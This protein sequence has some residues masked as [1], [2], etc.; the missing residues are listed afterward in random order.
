MKM[1][2]LREVVSVFS[3][4]AKGAGK[5]ILSY[6]GKVI[7]LRKDYVTTNEEKDANK[8]TLSLADLHTQ[9]FILSELVK[10]FPSF[11]ICSE[12]EDPEIIELEQR[13]SH[14]QLLLPAEYTIVIDPIDGTSNF[15]G[16]NAPEN[17]DN[18]AVQINLVYG[19]EMVAGIV[20]FPATEITI[21]T[22]KNGPTLINNVP[23]QLIAKPFS[24][25]DPCR[26]SSNY[27]L[28]LMTKAKLNY[29]SLKGLFSN[30]PSYGA[31][32]YNLYALLVQ[33]LDW[34]M[35]SSI[36]I[37]DFGCTALAYQNAGGFVGD[38]LGQPFEAN[39]SIV[40]VGD[41]Y[42]FHG[43]TIFAPTH[44]YL[45]DFLKYVYASQQ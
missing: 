18:F 10:F 4:I 23:Q 44:A 13:F 36:E 41:H 35:V 25:S 42:H 40:K 33:K 43:I 8:L 14:R 1:I 24:P 32:C 16:K 22:W 27:D 37:L 39:S 6:R 9:K 26:I 38:N 45:N 17:K 28:E 19:F 15:L 7:D 12:E 30:S 21:A 20:Y 34:Y 29:R 5:I 3:A 31:S 11:G 2:D